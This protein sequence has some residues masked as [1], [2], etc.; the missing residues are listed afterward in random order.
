MGRVGELCI[1]K[2]EARDGVKAEGV[3]HSRSVD[4]FPWK[5]RCAVRL[6]LELRLVRGTEQE[7]NKIH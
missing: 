1:G 7:R 2:V 3:L 5:G 4:G 6:L